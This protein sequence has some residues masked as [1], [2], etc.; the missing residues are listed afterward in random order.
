MYIII[1]K[2]ELDKTKLEQRFFY[3]LKG[4]L[5]LSHRDGSSQAPWMRQH[6]RQQM[7]QRHLTPSTQFGQGRTQTTQGLAPTSL[8]LQ[9]NRCSQ[10]LP[11]PDAARLRYTLHKSWHLGQQS[12]FHQGLCPPCRGTVPPWQLHSASWSSPNP[13]PP[14]FLQLWLPKDLDSWTLSD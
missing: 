12:C 6:M 7:H 4:S 14:R 11:S 8:L 13:I 9:Q 3:V 5:S 10:L 2:W 1:Y